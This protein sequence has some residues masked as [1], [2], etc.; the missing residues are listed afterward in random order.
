MFK[1]YIVLGLLFA[2][3]IKAGA[4]TPLRAQIHQIAQSA[5]GIVGVAVLGLEDRD[6]VTYNGNAR[7]VMQSVM[8]FPIAMAV[9]NQVDLGKIKLDESIRIKKKDLPKTYSP[10]RDKYPNGT[11]MPVSE[12]L[13]YMV[14]LSDNN[15]CDIL[16]KKLGGTKPVMDY[17]QAIGVKGIAIKASE[18][19]MAQ[20]W[21][22]Q[23][24]NW[25]QPVTMVNLLDLFYQGK[26][27]SKTSTDYLMKIMLETSTGPKQL[28]GLLPEGTLVAHKTGRSATNDAG[29]SPATNDVGIIT[30]PNGKHMAIAVFVCN[31]TADLT[32]RESVIAQ[33]AKAAWDDAVKK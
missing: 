10:I 4:Q 21:E 5:K 33:I 24:T 16:L 29:L 17:L 18:A 9:L 7:M 2:A 11:D 8:K 3:V 22:V 25:C 31:S 6:T 26:T 32:V 1:K 28:K 23:F 19:E 27:L 30:L 14:S 20:A 12:L 15:A 13:S